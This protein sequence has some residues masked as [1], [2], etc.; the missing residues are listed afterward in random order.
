M[1]LIIQNR[2]DRL[3][4]NLTSY[5]CQIII[6]HKRGL[7]IHKID[8]KIY[9]NNFFINCLNNLIDNINNNRSSDDK[10]FEEPIKLNI[11]DWCNLNML[12]CKETELDIYSYFCDNFKQFLLNEIKIKSPY[13]LNYNWK[14][15]I[16]IHLRLDDVDFNNRIDYDGEISSG[17]YRKCLNNNINNI[18]VNDELSYYKSIG[19]NDKLNL[20]NAQSPLSDEKLKPIIKKCTDKYP[21]HEVIIVCSP[22]GDITLPYK[23]IRSNDENFDLY[24]LIHSDILI[25][26]R[27]TYALTAAYLHMGTE[28]HIPMWGHFATTGMTSKYDKSN[29]NYFY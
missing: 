18:N 23:T 7:F 15:T 19:L 14:K 20:Y 26:S 4:A 17:F 29:L 13:E 1:S 9:A 12:C 2:G 5:L 22:I 28:I 11:D 27:S 21:E 25:C 24:C 8:N 3:G 16:C 10:E 6:A